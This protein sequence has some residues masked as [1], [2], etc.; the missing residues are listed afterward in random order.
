MSYK[1]DVFIAGVKSITPANF[2]D[3]AIEVLFDKGAPEARITTEQWVFVREDAELIRSKFFENA[4]E[5]VELKFIISDG[6]RSDELIQMIDFTRDHLFT[7]TSVMVTTIDKKGIDWLRKNAEGLTFREVERKG[8][9]TTSDFTYVKYARNQRV[10]IFEKA[11]ITGQ[12]V[13]I[14][15]AL[16]NSGTKI[17]AYAIEIVTII[18]T[19]PGILQLIAEIVFV[20]A[21]LFQ[22][23]I[24]LETAYDLFVQP[25]KVHAGMYVN[26][27]FEKACAYL[28]MTFESTILKNP[29]SPYNDLFIL[30]RKSEI[31]VVTDRIRGF[32]Q[33][34]QE[35]KGYY[36]NNFA[37]LIRDMSDVFN[38][39]IIIDG[40]VL[41]FERRDYKK[42]NSNYRLKGVYQPEEKYNTDEFVNNYIIEFLT[43]IADQNTIE[44]Y[45]GT[46][47][48]ATIGAAS[49]TDNTV[50][51]GATS[52]QIPFARAVKKDG[53]N[54]TET[55]MNE[56]F[57]IFSTQVNILILQVNTAID[58]INQIGDFIEKVNKILNFI[59]G[60]DEVEINIPDIPKIEPLPI[61]LIKN[62]RLDLL[63]LESDIVTVPKLFLL[64]RNTGKIR[65]DNETY[66]NSEYLLRNFHHINLFESDKPNQFK[67][68]EITTESFNY[69]D[70]LKVK[71]NN[72]IL[73][74]NNN[75]C[76]LVKCRWLLANS[77][78][79]IAYR[80]RF[81]YLNNL[82]VEYFTPDGK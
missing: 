33:P 64:S 11:F 26:Q 47:T 28:G 40:N 71:G 59:P 17:A 1:I 60:L 30:P 57:N 76:E 13:Y 7:D 54:F 25:I 9:I 51:G 44:K 49:R 45:L 56:L 50:G 65:S 6:V 63:V 73:D 19:V 29:A 42:P 5:P 3:L 55:I 77:R 34:S 72:L 39:K 80:C 68:K 27:L 10:D 16:I 46:I 37:Q 12:I 62:N 2:E 8:L 61:D 20:V 48:Q 4:L 24:I 36:E 23:L 31:P 58:L 79:E 15:A 38:G 81:K 70:F 21:L 18:A 69:A 78:A 52:V 14:S 53:L 41:R 66:L 75:E 32:L 22:F 67:E 74:E 82:T 43:D 35:Q